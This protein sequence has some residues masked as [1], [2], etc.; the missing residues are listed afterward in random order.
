MESKNIRRE[1]INPA[2][3]IEMGLHPCHYCDAG[4]SSYSESDSSSCREDCKYLKQHSKNMFIGDVMGKESITDDSRE[5]YYRVICPCCDGRGFQYNKQTGINE[6]C[7][8]CNGGGIGLPNQG[9]IEI[10]TSST[11]IKE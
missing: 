10:K 2:G 9:N 4:W 7:R 11:E 3:A 1:P 5:N 8:C 6:P